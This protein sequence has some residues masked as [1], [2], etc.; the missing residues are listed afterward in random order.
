MLP[1]NAAIPWKKLALGEYGHTIIPHRYGIGD[2]GGGDGGDQV[3]V[4]TAMYSVH[5]I[6]RPM[7][8]WRVARDGPGRRWTGICHS[9]KDYLVAPLPSKVVFI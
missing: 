1:T 2:I 8:I 3:V 9:D 4:A 6:A 7:V 5:R